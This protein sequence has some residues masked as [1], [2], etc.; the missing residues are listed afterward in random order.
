VKKQ[1]RSKRQ[2]NRCGISFIGLQA[3]KIGRKGNT[4]PA[5]PVKNGG[6]V[7]RCCDRKQEA[8]GSERLTQLSVG[9]PSFR[10]TVRSERNYF[11]VVASQ[12]AA[13]CVRA[14]RQLL[15]VWKAEGKIAR[16][17]GCKL[18]QESEKLQVSL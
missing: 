5:A 3:L 11:P 15:Q 9:R 14:G 7:L 1:K 13:R 16:A 4:K 18:F 12:E 2:D 6:S 17:A 10:L 8:F